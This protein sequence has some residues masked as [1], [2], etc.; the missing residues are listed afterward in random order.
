MW[1]LLLPKFAICESFNPCICQ[2]G[3]IAGTFKHAKISTVTV[4]EK[5][6]KFQ[7]YSQKHIFKNS[8]YSVCIIS[9]T[10]DVFFPF[11]LPSLIYGKQQ[12]RT[13][14]LSNEL[15]KLKIKYYYHSVFGC[16]FHILPCLK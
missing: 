13:P 16:K 15:Q 4:V 12:E 1:C 2:N 14:F 8:W 11:I 9:V 5:I 10:K 3:G 6:V 7:N